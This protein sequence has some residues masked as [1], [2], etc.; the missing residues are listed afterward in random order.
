MRCMV[1]AAVTLVIFGDTL[2]LPSVFL[3]LIESISE[4]AGDGA[5]QKNS[6]SVDFSQVL[7]D[8]ITVAD[9]VDS[10][11]NQARSYMEV[12]SS[13]GD[14]RAVVRREVDCSPGDYCYAVAVPKACLTWGRTRYHKTQTSSAIT[15]N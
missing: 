10:Q 5:L 1:S 7:L 9:E 3:I 11:L 12:E 14:P 8:V 13:T 6:S 15:T 2:Q 4:C